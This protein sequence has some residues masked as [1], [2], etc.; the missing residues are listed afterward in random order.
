MNLFLIGY[1]CAGKTSVGRFL[2]GVL[3]W[4]FIDAD[5]ELIKEQGMTIREIVSK[6]GWDDFREKERTVIKKLCALD[7]YVVATGGGSV[8]NAENVE[9]MKKSGVI[10]W[11]KATPDT[12]KNRILNDKNTEDGRPSLTAKGFLEEIEETLLSRNLHYEHAM[13]FFVDTNHLGIDDICRSV[14]RQLNALGI[15]DGK[16]HRFKR[17]QSCPA[18]PSEN[19]SK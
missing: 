14:I 16:I 2:A 11:L 5:S 17:K 10:V 3:G 13:D 8:L 1:R 15:K 18:T 4:H 12:I 9:D 6:G 7:G 19:Y